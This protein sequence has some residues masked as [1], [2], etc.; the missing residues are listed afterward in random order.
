MSRKELLNQLAEKLDSNVILYV[1]SDRPNLSAQIAPDV[2]DLF[3]EHF[4]KMD[5][6]KKL[7]LVIYSRGGSTMTAWWLV[8]LMKQFFDDFDV[9]IPSKAHSAATLIALGASNVIMTKQATLGPIDPSVNTPLN[10]EIPGAPINHRLPVSVEAIKGFI[11]L[12]RIEMGIN[13]DE[14]LIKVLEQLSKNVHP[15]VLGEVY[16]ARTQIQMIAKRLLKNSIEDE[17]RIKAIVYFLTS[18]SGSHDYTIHRTEARDV[19]GLNIQKP[20]AELYS[21]IKQLHD[22]YTDYCLMK[23]PF[24]PNYYLAGQ[25]IASYNAISALIESTAGCHQFVKSGIFQIN[26]EGQ[27]MEHINKEG[28][29]F[30]G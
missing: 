14:N 26:P 12:S 21:L 28:W 17:E 23:T 22:N 18:D 20:D 15:L 4:D 9:L 2:I 19:L 10:P 6:S 30:N 3:V 5:H 25:Q 7:T 29:E 8:N 16:R 11:D 27:L 1:T 13:D 24:T